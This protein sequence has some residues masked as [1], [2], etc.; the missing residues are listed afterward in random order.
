MRASR[1][2]LLVLGLCFP[3]GLAGQGGVSLEY[4]VKAAYLVN[5]TR[6]ISWPAPAEPAPGDPLSICVLGADPFGAVLD[7]LTHGQQSDGHPVVARRV[8]TVA[9]AAACQLVFV[10]HDEWRRRPDILRE[11]SRPGIVTIGESEDFGRAGGVISFVLS[12]ETVRFTVN[13]AARD[14]AGVK[15]SSRVLSLATVVFTPSEPR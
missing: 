8:R 14:R 10:S 6:Y 2:G 11:L 4:R 5:F 15:I 7:S 9:E 3:V 13:L 12:N 1:L